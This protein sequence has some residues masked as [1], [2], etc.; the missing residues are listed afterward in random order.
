MNYMEKVAEMLGVEFGEI[1]RLF[2]TSRKEEETGVFW[3]DKDGMYKE[4]PD[5]SKARIAFNWDYILTGDSEIVKLPWKPK[6]GESYWYYSELDIL[7]KSVW[8]GAL[9][10][11]AL[12]KLGKLYRTK[13]E[14]EKHA[15]EDAAYW[16]SIREEIDG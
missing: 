15:D 12:Y 5:G 14:A 2:D 11:L 16:E 9:F 8:D 13:A 7:E 10:D 3:I 4:Y 1:F 6:G